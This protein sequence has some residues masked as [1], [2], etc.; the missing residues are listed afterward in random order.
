[1]NCSTRNPALHQV[2][3]KFRYQVTNLEK[4][5]AETGVKIKIETK[6]TEVQT[7]EMNRTHDSDRGVILANND[8]PSVAGIAIYLPIHHHTP[9]LPQLQIPAFSPNHP[10]SSV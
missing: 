7:L 5:T 8:Q 9:I 3:R 4:T 1:M 6:D 2:T 10:I